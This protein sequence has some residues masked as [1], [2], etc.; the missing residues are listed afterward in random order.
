MLNIQCLIYFFRQFI[1]V[2]AYLDIMWRGDT[3]AEQCPFNLVFRGS[4]PDILL[5]A[6][7]GYHRLF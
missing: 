7:N 4:Q 3:N 6:D 1:A 5:P 2:D